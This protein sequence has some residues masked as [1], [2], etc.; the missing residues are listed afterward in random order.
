MIMSLDLW[1]EKDKEE[2]SES[3]NYTYNVSQMWKEATNDE[4]MI[5][6]EGLTGAEA[7]PLLLSGLE[8]LQENPEKFRAMNPDNKWGDYDRFILWIEQLIK[9][10]DSYPDAI[11]VAG[12]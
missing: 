1:M 10:C 9:E 3:F 4:K 5:P 11:W 7:K 6:I 12:R 2:I 8:K